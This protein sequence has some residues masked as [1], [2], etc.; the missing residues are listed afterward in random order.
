MGIDGGTRPRIV[1]YGVGQYG[2]RVT[3]EEDGKKRSYRCH[4]DLWLHTVMGIAGIP[5]PYGAPNANAHVERFVRTLREDALD[6]FIFLGVEHIRRVTASFVEYYNRARPS[7]AI[8][9]IPDP[10]C[11]LTEPPPKNGKL[12]ALPVLGGIHHDYRLAA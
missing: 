6:H 1:I 3:V 2:K 12:I 10:Y 7:Q 5:I 8:H 4:L 9:A 11:E